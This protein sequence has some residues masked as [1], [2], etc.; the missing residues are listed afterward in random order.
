MGVLKPIVLGL[1]GDSMTGKTTV[2]RALA[3]SAR[4]VED[5]DSFP[6]WWEHIDFYSSFGELASIR[7]KTEGARRWDRMAYGIHDVL[8]DLLG[9]PAYGGPD[10]GR[11]VKFVKWVC[12]WPGEAGPLFFAA[13][14]QEAQRLNPNCTVQWMQRKIGA[15]HT[16]FRSE[17]AEHDSPPVFGI[18]ISDVMMPH[19]FAFIRDQSSSNILVKLV[20]T[21]EVRRDRADDGEALRS[22]PLPPDDDFDAVVD[23]SELSRAAMA[24][25][26]LNLVRRRLGMHVEEHVQDRSQRL[27]AVQ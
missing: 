3:P 24:D 5:G 18:V 16:Y 9:Y 11:L 25:V 15:A 26:V 21:P 10:Y 22:T 2:A 17:F 7:T 6:F 27:R 20:A 1:A 8:V 4:M 19:E 12:N 13:A 23:T 14:R